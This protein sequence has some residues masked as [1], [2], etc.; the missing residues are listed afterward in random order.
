[1]KQIFSIWLL[2]AKKDNEY[3]SKII[4][5]LSYKHGAPVFIPHL[6]IYGGKLQL[7]PEKAKKIVVESIRSVKPFTI[8]VDKLNQSENFWK[9][10]FIEIKMNKY[11][12]R[13][14][15]NLRKKLIIYNDYELKPHM[16]LIY[17]NLSTSERINIINSLKIKNKYTINEIAINSYLAHYEIENWRLLSTS[18]LSPFHQKYKFHRS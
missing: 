18:P 7:D 12:E 15:Q 9:T 11:L 10:V 8:E 4:K 3:L 5:D 14:Y 13:I 1:M 16:S 6:T 2:P 17:K